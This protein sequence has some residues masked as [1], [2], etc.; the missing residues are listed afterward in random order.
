MSEQGRRLAALVAVLAP[1]RAGALLSR[2]GG[3]AEPDVMQRAL[4]LATLSRRERL[5]ALAECVAP[6]AAA[7]R[8]A[9]AAAASRERARVSA[10][11]RALAAGGTA[12]SAGQLL[13]RLCRERI[14]R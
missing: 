5:Q 4:R 14:C 11:M 3:P 2:L 6:D 8:S 10:F 12:P 1:K 13:T 7:V 9:T